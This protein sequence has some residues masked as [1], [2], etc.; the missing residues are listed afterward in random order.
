MNGSFLLDWSEHGDAQENIPA[1][2]N[3]AQAGGPQEYGRR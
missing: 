1:P 2:N 3:H